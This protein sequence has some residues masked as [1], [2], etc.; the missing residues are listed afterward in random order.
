LDVLDRVTVVLDVVG[1]ERAG[2]EWELVVDFVDYIFVVKTGLEEGSEVVKVGGS[3]SGVVACG[4]GFEQE[5]VFVGRELRGNVGTTPEAGGPGLYF[6]G[7]AGT[8]DDL[9]FEDIDLILVVRGGEMKRVVGSW[10]LLCGS[11]TFVEPMVTERSGKVVEVGFDAEDEVN[12]IGLVA[13][14]AGGHRCTSDGI[15]GERL[16]DPA[17]ESAE[18]VKDSVFTGEWRAHSRHLIL[19]RHLVLSFQLRVL[20][21]AG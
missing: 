12:V 10:E 13:K 11:V 21:F 8:T 3:V 4:D 2:V 7:E 19:R 5:D 15:D 20:R 6:V 14:T 9:G 18:D 1:F 16:G 17:V